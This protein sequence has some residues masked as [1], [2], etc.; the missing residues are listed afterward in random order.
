MNIAYKA[1]VFLVNIGKMLP[2]ILCTLLLLSYTESLYAVVTNNVLHYYDVYIYYVPLSQWI[3]QYFEY[4]WLSV[5]VTLIISVAVEAC[6]WNLMAVLYLGIHLLFKMW[7]VDIELTEI[8][9]SVICT[10][11]IL[12]TMFF[13]YKGIKQL[14]KK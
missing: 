14:C 6:I 5:I 12:I 10:L 7:V 9:I 8:Q 13:I 4:D 3:A 2:F 1:R 11:N